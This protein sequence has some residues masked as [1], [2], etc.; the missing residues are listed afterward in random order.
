MNRRDLLLNLALSA[1]AMPLAS[2]DPLGPTVLC[3][4]RADAL[5]ARRLSEYVLPPEARRLIGAVGDLIVPPTDTAGATGAGVVEFSEF[6]LG[7]WFAA[8]ERADFLKGLAALDA[9]SRSSNGVGFVAADSARQNALLTLLESQALQTASGTLD[10]RSF[11][12]RIKLLV[13]TGYYTSE[14]GASVE[15]D[16]TMVFA[17]FEGCRELGPDDRAQC[18][19]VDAPGAI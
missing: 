16:D 4:G 12:S 1:A 7:N 17:A 3:S 8:T 13:L 9:M 6:M 11:I 15:L 10:P 2:S 14:V 19:T 5:P 18:R